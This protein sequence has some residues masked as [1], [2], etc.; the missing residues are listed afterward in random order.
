M[1][2]FEPSPI[3][4]IVKNGKTFTDFCEH[5]IPCFQFNENVPDS[6]KRRFII[7]R[8]LLEYSYFEY[9]FTD[10]ALEKCYQTF[11]L[12][13][14]LKYQEENP[15]NKSKKNFKPYLEWA[16]LKKHLN[17][18]DEMKKNLEYLR[19]HITHLKGDSFSGMFCLKLI[20]TIG[21]NFINDLYSIKE[22]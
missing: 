9:E 21:N 15:D 16:I 7:I 13:L 19:N 14:S 11:E 4:S 2:K 18:T 10:V 5:I 12:A 17:L 3:W 22:I 6:I 1:N 8:K 20:N